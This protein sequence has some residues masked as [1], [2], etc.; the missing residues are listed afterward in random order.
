MTWG[1]NPLNHLNIFIWVRKGKNKWKHVW[2]FIKQSDSA[3]SFCLFVCFQALPRKEKIDFASIWLWT[4]AGLGPRPVEIWQEWQAASWRLMLI[5]LVSHLRVTCWLMKWFQW[6]HYLLHFSL[7]PPV[8]GFLSA[9]NEHIIF[10]AARKTVTVC[11]V[12]TS[13]KNKKSCCFLKSRNIFR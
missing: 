10:N 3:T 7:S 4:T 9:D 13:K 11:P 6:Q 1:S 8:S 12:V 5:N 2:I